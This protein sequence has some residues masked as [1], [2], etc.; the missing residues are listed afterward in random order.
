[1]K[2]IDIKYMILIFSLLLLLFVVMIISIAMGQ[3]SINPVTVIS[4]LLGNI[5][6]INTTWTDTMYRVVMLHRFPRI[7]A[8]LLVGG[9]L[10][11]AGASYQGIFRNPLV[12]PD[13]L[14]V[15]VGACLGAA[16]SIVLNLGHLGNIL[17][18][19]LGG[20][21]AVT[22]TIMIPT[23]IK[24]KATIALVLSG[25]IVGGFFSSVLGL[26]HYIA[27]PETQLV[28]IVYW[29]LGSLARIR[30]EYLYS[31][32]PIII[33]TSLLLYL[34]RWRI[35]VISL[36][37]RESKA[38]GINLYKERSLLIICAT[39][40]TA[41]AVCLSG[42]IGWIGL[43]IPHL[44]RM[45][46]GQDNKKVIPVSIVIGATFLIIID[47]ISRNLTGAEIPLGVITGFVG[48][49]FFVFVLFKQKRKE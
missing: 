7:I 5:F 37:D 39:L 31:I 27:D 21:L 42:T 13:L 24:Q 43:V 26:L 33:V 2:L 46:V 11:L 32:G 20:I 22:I 23:L 41:A 30:V 47:T 35:N 49:P 17:L 1:M 18:A 28:Q 34:L 45:I 14:G 44:A 15:S 16:V 25:V 38:L 40:L 6:P 19:F 12:S 9:A 29:Q 3:Y 36:G 10:S 4:I 8:A 48:T